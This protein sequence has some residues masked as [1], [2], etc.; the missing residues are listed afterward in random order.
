MTKEQLK[1]ILIGLGV[2][3]IAIVGLV[4]YL[5]QPKPTELLTYQEYLDLLKAY[6]AKI[7]YIKTNCDRDTR[8]IK[9]KGE[10]KVIFQQ[11]KT[12]DDLINKLNE[13]IKT[14]NSVFVK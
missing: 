1:Q 13:W 14:E 8:C 5:E 6:N 7:E 4:A 3:T 10:P 9:D 2:G 11:V 12:K